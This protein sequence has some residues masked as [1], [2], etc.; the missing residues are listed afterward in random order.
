MVAIDIN[1][2]RRRASSPTWT[3]YIP[4]W[5]AMIASTFSPLAKISVPEEFA[6]REGVLNKG[7]VKIQ[8]QSYQCQKLACLRTICFEGAGFQV[9][10]LIAVPRIQYDLPIFGVDVVSLPGGN[11]CSIDYQPAR[12]DSIPFAQPLYSSARLR[13]AKWSHAFPHGG[14]IP[15][16]A[17]QFFSPI[18]LWTRFPH[19]NAEELF[20]KVNEA[21]CEYTYLYG[22]AL[23]T[24]LPSTD[25]IHLDNRKVATKSYLE[26]RILHDPASGILNKT[27]GEEWTGKFL[28]KYAFPNCSSES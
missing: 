6:N 15:P 1:N 25:T 19:S 13:L 7:L 17:Q 10:N 8:L 24:C 4:Q 23:T 20:A 3:S 21:L 2:G 26:Y 9:F 16:N 14:T 18:A 5:E 28:E 27:F 12:L 11:L 22:E